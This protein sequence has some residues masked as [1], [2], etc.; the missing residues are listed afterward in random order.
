MKKLED[1]ILD[2]L[3]EERAYKHMEFLVNE[4]GERL[5]GTEKIKKAAN[6]IKNEMET[7]GLDTRIDNFYMYHS[8]PKNA[9]LRVTYPETRVITAKPTCHIASTL[10]EGI[11]GE[12][13]YAGVGGYEDYKGKNVEG[14]IVLTG[15]T[16]APP[17]PEKARIA[18]EKGAKALI[19]MNWGPTNNPVIQ[20][21][22]T[23]SQWGNP[24]PETFRDI[25]QIP[26]IAITRAAGEYLKELCIKE[27]VKVWLRAEATRE[28]VKANQPIGILRGKKKPEEFIL[29][30]SHLEAW[31]KTAICNSSG[32]SLTLEL[33]RAFAKHKDELER[34]IVFAFWDGHE[35]AEA[36]G[37]TWFVDNNWDDL[38]KH[39]IAYVN[40][41]NPGIIG[42]SLPG[43][44]G[45]TELK[46]FLKNI[47][48]EEWKK[49]AKWSNAYKGGDES[50]FGVGVPYIWFATEYTLEKIKELNYASLSPWLHSEA[51][52]IDK[53]DKDLHAKH[54]RFDGLLVSKLCNMLVIPYNCSLVADELE[55]DLKQLKNIEGTKL[56][57]RLGSLLNEVAEFKELTKKL[58]NYKEQIERLSTQIDDSKKKKEVEEIANLINQTL[59]KI[60]RNIS[61]IMRSEAGRYGQDPYGYSLVG[62]PIPILYTSLTKLAKL[63]EGSEEFILWET[64]FTRERNRVFD[65]I[66]NSI[67]YILLASTLIDEKLKSITLS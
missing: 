25:P 11:E 63:K 24:T 65:V 64:K 46:D 61:P 28:W 16:W 34:S 67:D 58:E 29:V 1:V 41:D 23:K 30:G 40:V 6:Y 59:L 37:S 52:T 54:L 39:C 49:E 22:G 36:A 60:S 66:N 10:P 21:G 47:I 62:K 12:L 44:H 32:N 8:Y 19:I 42:T 53:I 43:V 18:Y 26:V 57:S 50:F 9:E 35:V 3:S 14:K 4:V 55:G 5:A 33:A 48:K 7:Y 56:T 20:M 31:G 13:I 17:R 15:M 38:T 27:K 51:D 45:V 2:E